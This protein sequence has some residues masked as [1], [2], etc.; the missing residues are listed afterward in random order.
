MV[1]LELNGSFSDMRSIKGDWNNLHWQ[2]DF[3]ALL[4]FDKLVYIIKKTAI[5]F[6]YE[7]DYCFL[8]QAYLLRGFEFVKTGYEGNAQAFQEI[9]PENRLWKE[10][11]ESV[12][13]IRRSV[14]KSK[15][16]GE[17]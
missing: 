4:P 15:S 12:S 5:H 9:K 16:G 14:L 3:I 17:F 1:N 10:Y 7:I 13:Q 2:R 11:R 6:N 8:L